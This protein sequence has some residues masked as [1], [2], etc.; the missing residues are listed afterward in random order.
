VRREHVP[1]DAAA[2]RARVERLLE[3]ARQVIDL[4][5]GTGVELRQRLVQTTGLSPEGVQLGITRALELYPSEEEM[6]KLCNTAPA[7]PRVWVVLSANVFVAAHRAIALALASS[8]TV[9]VKP[10]RRDPA[11]AEAL[12]V[13]CGGLFSIVPQLAVESGDHVYAYGSD[14][15]MQELRRDLPTGA[16]FH[17]HGTGMGAAFVTASDSLEHAAREIAT[18]VVTF[19]QRGCLSPRLVALGPGVDGVAF[20]AQLATE[21]AR[22]ETQVPMGQ[23]SRAE[24]GE[25]TWYRSVA[26][27]AGHVFDAGPGCVSY[28]PD[29]RQVPIPP[30]LRCVSVFSP[31]DLARALEASAKLLT[32]VAADDSVLRQRL[33]ES[34]PYARHVKLGAMQCPLFDGPVDRRVQ[35]SDGLAS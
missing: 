23:S 25:R 17:A 20:A 8:A 29:P 27:Y 22:W 26:A 18:D 13:A 4:A 11:L 7:A 12:C 31:H 24:Q 6:L 19:D 3:S 1:A 28:F 21:L 15:T 10:S 9:F 30:A 35:D 32:V 34:Y 2:R 33:L 16:I 14:S 5:G